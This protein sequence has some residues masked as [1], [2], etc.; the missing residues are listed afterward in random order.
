M[1]F[2]RMLSVRVSIRLAEELEAVA[3]R[4]SNQTST[5]VRRLLSEALEQG[6]R[7]DRRASEAAE[8]GRS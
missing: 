3:R 6:R 7:N 8:R 1:D 2:D 4:E 5:V